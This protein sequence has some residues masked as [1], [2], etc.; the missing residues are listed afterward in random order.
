MLEL[1]F[2]RGGGVVV[3]WTWIRRGREIDLRFYHKYMRNVSQ[4]LISTWNVKPAF[5]WY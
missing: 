1:G 4:M 3:A 2:M 5:K